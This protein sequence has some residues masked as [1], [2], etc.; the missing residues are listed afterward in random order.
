LYLPAHILKQL[1]PSA[2]LFSHF[3][4]H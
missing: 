3:L 2:E 4:T 1:M